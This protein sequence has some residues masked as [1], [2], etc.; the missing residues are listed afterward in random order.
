[1]GHVIVEPPAPV[2]PDMISA[3]D[4]PDHITLS[5]VVMLC[6]CLP[7]GLGA[8][9]YSLECKMAKMTGRKELAVEVRRNNNRFNHK[10]SDK[11]DPRLR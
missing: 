5:A 2:L 9:V 3:Y 6:C 11:D 7:I 1:M 10:S 8:F 4:A